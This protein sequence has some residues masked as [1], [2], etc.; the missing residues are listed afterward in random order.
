[1]S[2]RGGGL[3]RG[4]PSTEGAFGHREC[5]AQLQMPST[6]RK[7]SGFTATRSEAGASGVAREGHRSE[8]PAAARAAPGRLV[9]LVVARRQPGLR[10]SRGVTATS[11]RRRQRLPRPE[12]SSGR[13]SL[14]VDSSG[15]PS[16]LTC[17]IAAQ[18]P[19]ET[20]TGKGLRLTRLS[21]EPRATGGGLRAR[22]SPGF[23]GR[24]KRAWLLGPPFALPSLM[25]PP[26][27]KGSGFIVGMPCPSTPA[28]AAC[29]QSSCLTASEL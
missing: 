18:V 22:K 24:E 3:G 10:A 8:R 7:T 28:R 21:T 11:C 6:R 15:R 20:L 4:S 14:L 2:W 1:M 9:C 26:S 29:L 16:S 13:N 23:A 27:R 25:S 12:G 17:Q 19:C 5:R